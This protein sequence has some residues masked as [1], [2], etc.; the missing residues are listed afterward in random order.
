MA[1]FQQ[2]MHGQAVEGCL[3][4]QFAADGRLQYP[5]R[6]LGGE[7][8]LLQRVGVLRALRRHDGKVK[9]AG[10]ISPQTAFQQFGQQTV[11][12]DAL[13]PC[14]AAEPDAVMLA[15][16]HRH[17]RQHSRGRCAGFYQQQDIF[18]PGHILQP[19][20]GVGAVGPG[21]LAAQRHQRRQI[22]LCRFAQHGVTS[23]FQFVLQVQYLHYF[24]GCCSTPQVS[25]R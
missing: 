10:P 9:A 3:G 15:V 6:Q 24:T 7:S 2:F 18:Q 21:S 20:C 12:R 13:L 1:H 16:F 14:Q 25:R 8:Q 17:S 4:Q 19:A 11:E 5:Q 22:I 23:F